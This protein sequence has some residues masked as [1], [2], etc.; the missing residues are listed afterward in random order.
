MTHP[1]L[2]KKTPRSA[3]LKPVPLT[4]GLVVVLVG[5]LV[6]LASHA[7]YSVG[8]CDSSGYA[9]LARSLLRGQVTLPITG[10]DTF[11]LPDSYAPVFTPLAYTSIGKNGDITRAMVPWYPIG[12]PLH[13]AAGALLLG[14]R[15]GPFL[16]SPLLAALSCWFVF[17]I[18][19]RLGLARPL[20]V[21]GALLLAVNPSFILM[22]LQPVS[23]ITATFWAVM[24]IWAG[25]RSRENERWSL[26]AG[27]AFGLA[28]LV[29]PANILLLAPLLFCIP[30]R[31]RSIALFV[32]GG[33]PLAAVFFA[34]NYIVFGH[35]L[36]TGYSVIGLTRHFIISGMSI[37]FS[38]YAYW[39]SVTMTPLV[40]VAWLGVAFL[41]S[42]DWRRRALLIAWFGTFLIFYC[43]YEIFEEWA[44][45]RFL[46]PGYPGLII[47][48]LLTAQTMSRSLIGRQRALRLAAGFALL[49][50]M[51]VVPLR[52]TYFYN[53]LS[54]GAFE[55]IH[56]DSIRMALERLPAKAV[57][58]SG[59]TSGAIHFYTERTVM[60][61]EDIVP[62]RWPTLKSSVLSSG[63]DFYALLMD[64]E[65]ES[66]QQRVPGHWDEVGRVRQC[67][68]WHIQP[69]DRPLPLIRYDSG[70]YGLERVADGVEW[71][72]MSNEGVVLLQNTAKTMR[73]RIEGK[74]PA[75]GFTKPSTTKL[76][77]NGRPL[78]T[79]VTSE[80]SLVREYQITPAQQGSGEWTELR[81]VV[82]QAVIPRAVD[83][84]YND[85]RRLSFSLTKLLWEELTA[86]QA[87]LR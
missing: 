33:S 66:A 60:R 63:Y 78:E 55:L 48:A 42:V 31:L 28:F 34:Y 1:L 15:L 76:L 18:G 56:H 3:R 29:R 39:L 44:G 25:L 67:A 45:T 7:G 6:T 77:L 85:D 49:I 52:F 65:L 23:D 54:V 62:V 70:F 86:Q 84:A 37:R 79:V 24:V 57:V 30:L 83:P 36:R 72:W 5:Y 71:N 11:S 68:L 20:A 47:G 35:P 53:V 10:L 81:I 13:E 82:D 22:A 61:F 8:G 51:F 19:L 74:F 2:P 69:L 50:P 87:L 73:L 17:C 41:R 12:F 4:L 43:G 21:A 40:L 9:N 32:L 14:W 80:H 26:L 59:E 27:L 38:S 58:V 75:K 46:L 16:I 64:S